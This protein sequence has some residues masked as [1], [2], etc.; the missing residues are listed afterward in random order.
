[1]KGKE[2]NTTASVIHVLPF[3]HL[4]LFWLGNRHECF[5]RG[6]RI[7]REAIRLCRRDRSFRFL[8]E[9]AVFLDHYLK[10]H[11]GDARILRGLMRKGQMEGTAKWAAIMITNVKG[12]TILR[13]LQH[14]MRFSGRFCGRPPSS[15]HLGDLPGLPFQLP[16]I[17]S[18]CGLKTV[19]F[20]RGGPAKTPLFRWQGPAGSEAL[21]WYS[22]KCYNWGMR[23]AEA[24]DVFFGKYA[25]TLATETEIMV[26]DA[27]THIL[28]HAGFDL[29]VPTE[30]IVSNV[31][32]WNQKARQRMRI[33]TQEEFFRAVAGADCPR[34]QG[35]LPTVWGNWPD[36][37]YLDVTI[38]HGA[39]ERALLRA[40]RMAA[41]DVMEGLPSNLSSLQTAW[42]NLFESLDHNYSLIAPEETHATKVRLAQSA[43]Q[44]AD[45][46]SLARM[47]R[48][49]SR[50]A[51]PKACIP[52]IV[53]NPS[54]FDRT[55]RITQRVIVYGDVYHN[56]T[57]EWADFHLVD[58]DGLVVPFEIMRQR[59]CGAN[60]FDIAF[61]AC[62]V[63]SLGYRTWYLKP[64]KI[65]ST[66]KNRSRE[67]HADIAVIRNDRTEVRFDRRGGMFCIKG[68]NGKVLVERLEVRAVEQDKRNQI[69]QLRPTGRVKRFLC[70]KVTVSTG[71]V[72]N[73]MTVEGTIGE[74]PV[75][76]A[77]ALWHGMEGI[78]V[79]VRIDHA[80]RGF[81]RFQL[82]AVLPG[83]RRKE[84]FV[85]TPFGG[86]AFDNVLPGCKPALDD[87]V[88]PEEWKNLREAQDW[89]LVR[90][91]KSDR[92]L[93][94]ATERKL[95]ELLP[96]GVAVNLLSSMTAKWIHS[97]E[98]FHPFAGSYVS[99]FR[100][101]P[102]PDGD[103]ACA[104]RL[105]EEFF[106]PCAVFCD[107][108]GP[109][110]RDLGSR[111]SWLTVKSDT[112]RLTALKPVE[113]GRGVIARFVE[114]GGKTS[115][116]AINSKCGACRV[117][118]CNMIEK[119]IG[120]VALS[121]MRFRPFEIRTIR[122]RS[123][124]RMRTCKGVL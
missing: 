89:L 95:V 22:P 72:V 35:E 40:E 120:R 98:F 34:L 112:V 2:I 107:Y 19:V 123:K 109:G 73:R 82:Y 48:I 47:A 81:L 77:V 94:L 45:D 55:D 97:E 105:G 13:N 31:K 5:S 70:R 16:Q 10:T 6:A 39:A 102:A 119:S 25:E 110:K 38:H 49:A 1:M 76:V 75:S 69:M 71:L 83:G 114:A 93:I 36:P 67:L 27:G 3:S 57:R 18:G 124:K 59:M 65:K 20:S 17:I 63:P 103:L 85:G 100:I 116:A 12:E 50:V 64:G 121:D 86:N 84:G 11:P 28:M 26:G 87:E 99:R 37:A 91:R 9:D 52:I 74:T 58:D 79:S 60:Q 21:S 115:R 106:M 113:D 15:L 8:I 68:R 90:A 46:I 32:K 78:D 43:M 29:S 122:L 4:D 61:V 88:L 92:A 62:D 56:A 117:E 7:I 111:R 30:N 104:A 33:A 42:R 96:E 80:G 41:L 118:E 23:L 44:A 108:S 51:R 54:S 66:A 14:G 101:T 53:F 24:P